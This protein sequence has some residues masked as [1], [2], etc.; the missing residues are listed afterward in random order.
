MSAPSSRLRNPFNH[1]PEERLRPLTGHE[2]ELIECYQG[3]N[4][5]ALSN[6]LLARC[7]TQP[8]AP[9]DE[10]LETVRAMTVMERNS[11]LMELR[12]TTLGDVVRAEVS[13]PKCGATDQ[14]DFQLSDLPVEALGGVQ[15]IETT[16][17]D[18]THVRLRLPTAG[19]QA[20]L[21]DQ[22]LDTHSAQV[23]WL[24]SRIIERFGENVGPLDVDSTRGLPIGHRRQLEVAIDERLPDM[25]LNMEVTCV[26]CAQE[27]TVPFEIISFFLTK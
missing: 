15:P 7:L 13:C 24:L 6:E 3:S 27:Y 17:E 21:M 9:I 20:D 4:P 11:A 12:R 5:S 19:D 10:T 25:D 16:L 22:E 1:S 23:S 14:V 2:E 26:E 8:G 18:G